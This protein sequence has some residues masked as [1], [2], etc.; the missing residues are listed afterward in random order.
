MRD[1]RTNDSLKLSLAIMRKAAYASGIQNIGGAV[2]ALANPWIGNNIQPGLDFMKRVNPA[3]EHAQNVWANPAP[4]PKLPTPQT[5]AVT[6]ASSPALPS[7]GSV[8]GP[9][10]MSGANS[11]APS[12]LPKSGAMM[13]P[14]TFPAPKMPGMMGGPSL[15]ASAGSVFKPVGAQHRPMPAMANRFGSKWFMGGAA[16]SGNGGAPATT[17]PSFSAPPAG[18]TAGPGMSAGT[19]GGGYSGAAGQK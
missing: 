8:G 18:G 19:T 2:S 1:M 6:P 5:P 12:F 10:G 17:T 4:G 9:S 15:P 14:P 16:G 7:L 13:K 3:W 11:S